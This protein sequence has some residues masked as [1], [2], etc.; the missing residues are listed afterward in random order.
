MARSPRIWRIFYDKEE[1]CIEALS[2]SEGLVRFQ[3]TREGIFDR[4]PE[5]LARTTQVHTEGGAPATP[6]SPSSATESIH[7]QPTQSTPLSAP[8]AT[9][10]PIDSTLSPTATTFI[11]AAKRQRMART[12]QVHMVPRGGTSNPLF[13]IDRN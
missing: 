7:A 1:N 4:V 6:C 8:E 9:S 3:F 11:P 5:D 13:T 2:D 12:T 10:I